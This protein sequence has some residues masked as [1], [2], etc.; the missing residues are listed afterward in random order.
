MEGLGPNGELAYSTSVTES[1]NG[2]FAVRRHLFLEGASAP[3]LDLGPVT[4]LANG[5]RIFWADG[6]VFVTT[7]TSLYRLNR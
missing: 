5:T 6:Q 7:R 4:E 2:S 1:I 3:A